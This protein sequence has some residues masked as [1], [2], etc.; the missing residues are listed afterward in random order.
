MQQR[1]ISR[2][3]A[4]ALYRDLVTRS[5]SAPERTATDAISRSA[6]QVASTI[7]AKAIVASRSTARPCCARP[8]AARA[9]PSSPSRPTSRSRARS[10]MSL[11]RAPVPRPRHE[12]GSFEAMLSSRRGDTART[13][14]SDPDGP[15]RRD[16]GLPFGTPGAANVLRVISAAGPDEWDPSLCDI[17]TEECGPTGGFS[18]AARAARLCAIARRRR[19]TTSFRHH[20]C[21]ESGGGGLDLAAMERPG[22]CVAVGGGVLIRTGRNGGLSRSDGALDD[23]APRRSGKWRRPRSALVESS[24]LPG[25]RRHRACASRARARSRRPAGSTT[26]CIPQPHGAGDGCRPLAHAQPMLD[27]TARTAGAACS[28]GRWGT[29][30][31][32]RAGTGRAR[33]ARGSRRSSRRADSRSRRPSGRAEARVAEVRAAVGAARARADVVARVA[34]VVR[35]AVAAVRAALRRDVDEADVE[36]RVLA[37]A[38]HLA[39]TRARRAIGCGS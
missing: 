31:A 5:L 10:R 33:G 18:P 22:T 11:G 34:V 3:E 15:R 21:F 24:R 16:G 38:Q 20:R 23:G 13:A 39:R 27:R 35:D 26:G 28:R 36:R 1:V 19:P 8:R 25:R 4:D 17:R 29:S 37:H 9:C 14:V 6:R 32:R 12:H 7:G 2:V 30:T